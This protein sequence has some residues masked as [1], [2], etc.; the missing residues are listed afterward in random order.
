MIN[1]DSTT[2]NT[3]IIFTYDIFCNTCY[4][5]S[6]YWIKVKIRFLLIFSQNF[7]SRWPQDHSFLKAAVKDVILVYHL[8]NKNKVQNLTF[9][10][11]FSPRVTSCD[12]ETHVFR[13]VKFEALFWRS[14]AFFLIKIW[15][16][17]G[18]F[19]FQNQEL[20]LIWWKVKLPRIRKL[21]LWCSFCFG[22]VSR[23]GL[24]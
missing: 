6:L 8:P 9:P 3:A 14:S 18:I 16:Q 5:N 17:Y 22:E 11:I 12:L 21:F 2:F 7:W 24:K 13:K 23:W 20:H 10:Y 19:K 4:D 1:D 15:P